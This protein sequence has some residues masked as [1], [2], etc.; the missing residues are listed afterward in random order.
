[1]ARFTRAYRWPHRLPPNVRKAAKR[2]AHYT[3]GNGNNPRNWP[4]VN[5][6]TVKRMMRPYDP[7]ASLI[8]ART[9]A[10]ETNRAQ[11]GLPLYEEQSLGDDGPAFLPSVR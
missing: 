2:V 7:S 10:E 8:D 5:V 6:D 9:R 11:S 3:S 4:S 1:M